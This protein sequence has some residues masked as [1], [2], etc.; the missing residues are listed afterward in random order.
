MRVG[1]LALEFVLSWRLLRRG[2]PVPHFIVVHYSLVASGAAHLLL[3][4]DVPGR[5]G[6]RVDLHLSWDDQPATLQ[7][8]R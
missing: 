4:V 2:G 5:T 1:W 7:L 3:A 6:K 8:L